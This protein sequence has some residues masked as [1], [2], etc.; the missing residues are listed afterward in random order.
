MN[1]CATCK[2]WRGP[3]PDA[4][5]VFVRGEWHTYRQAPC[6]SEKMNTSDDDGAGSDD[7]YGQIETGPEF[8]CIHHTPKEAD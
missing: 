2:W 4:K 5:R 8:G 1:T 7:S 3:V 6:H